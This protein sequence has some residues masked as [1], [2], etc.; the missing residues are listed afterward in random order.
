MP[1]ISLVLSGAVSLG[2][3]EA[4]VLDELLYVLDVLN[5][6]RAPTQR[7]RID[8]ITG[9]SAGA[10][11][12]ALVAEAVMVDFGRRR[13]LRDAW[14]DEIDIAAL[15]DRAPANALLSSDPIQRIAREFL[16]LEPGVAPVPSSMAPERLRMTFTVTNL[17]GVD[18][19]LPRRDGGH[20]GDGTAAG[21]AFTGTFFAEQRD[22][23]VDAGTAGD[24]A[25]WGGVREAAIASG[26][27]PLAFAPHRLPSLAAAFPDN[28]LEPWPDAFWYVD[29]GL[30]NNE[31]LGEAVR[32]SRAADTAADGGLAADR[33][34]LLVDANLN[35]SAHDPAFDGASPLW[36]I[37]LRVATAVRGEAAANDWLEALRKNNEVSWRDGLV[38]QMAGMVRALEVEEP[39]RLLAELRCSAEGIVARKRERL[40]ADRYPADYVALAIERTRRTWAGEMEGMSELRGDVFATLVFLLNSV[41]GLDSK[42]EL[43]LHVIFSTPEETAGDQLSAFAGFLSREWREHDYTVGRRAARRELP[44]VLGMDPSRMPVPEPGVAYEPTLDLGSVTLA[45]AP[46]AGRERLR[47]AVVAKID[48]VAAEVHVG[49]RWLNR[50]SGPLVRWLARRQAGLFLDRYL[51]L[52]S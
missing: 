2:S 13:R 27:F 46:R 11:T 14:V 45:N 20:P 9:A 7:Y 31:P 32:L 12:A 23:I 22:F 42:H 37:G 3:F 1:A 26:D 36:R 39:A 44:A 19:R 48:A 43:D 5:R 51:G 33:V 24:P 15:L 50:V 30:F 34:F 6:N 41:A 52:R 29:G 8:V 38:H 17:T 28:A 16:A 35:R 18:Y 25:F 21:D 4:G 47:D 40:G 49:P 10:M